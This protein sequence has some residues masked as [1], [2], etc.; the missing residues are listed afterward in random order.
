MV[1]ATHQNELSGIPRRTNLYIK[2]YKNS[3]SNI[4]AIKKVNLL[5]KKL[6][7]ILFTFFPRFCVSSLIMHFSVS[8]I[9]NNPHYLAEKHIAIYQAL[10]T[11]GTVYLRN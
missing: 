9:L 3:N 7:P 2:K 4:S 1:K 6:F 11:D 8:C 10:Y 5:L